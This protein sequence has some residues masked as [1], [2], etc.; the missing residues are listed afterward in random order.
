MSKFLGIELGSTRIKAVLVDGS[1]EV[2]AT[3]SYNWENKLEG[4]Y[5]TY[6]LDE[7]WV[8]LQSC[9][10]DLGAAL[11]GVTA[12]GISAMMHGYLAFDRMGQL[13]VPFRTWRN[14]SAGPAADELSAL[15][16]FHLP[17]RWSASHLYQAILNDEK[18]VKDIAYITTLAGYVHWR[19]TGEQVL[20]IGD[21][22]GMF[23]ID[24]DTLDYHAG[25]LAQFDA[26]AQFAQ[27]K[28]HCGLKTILPKIRAA[29]QEAGTLTEEGARLLDPTGVLQAGIPLCPPEGD[30]GTGMVA[31]NSVTARSGNVSAG[32]SIFAMVV[33][34]QSLSAALREIDIVAT[35]AGK[36]VAMVHCNNCTSDIDA[37]AGLFMQVFDQ[38]GVDIAKPDL[39]DALYAAA[40]EGKAD[41][42]GLLSYNFYA[43]EPMAGIETGGFLLH[44][45]PGSKF[46]PQNLMRSLVFSSVASLRIGLD[47][48]VREQVQLDRIT[49]HGGLFKSDGAQQ[50]V[51]AALGVPVAVMASAGEGGA[52]G[53]AL[54]AAYM[55]QRLAG[56]SLEDYLEQKVFAGQDALAIVPEDTD[57][58]GFACYLERYKQGLAA[59][60]AAGGIK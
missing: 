9:V 40:L 15:F 10:R 43:A 38:M 16:E 56:E 2:L 20:G 14:T 53:I 13:L 45:K 55:A 8:G 58:Q 41:C 17:Q 36:Q 50:L 26:Q 57:R 51:A 12:M 44:R 49:G 5:W 30:A 54:L 32:T 7:A 39:Y 59:A 28:P 4:G 37:W 1:H 35:P 11:Q 52:W 48:L 24:S 25:M 60:R 47:I 18:H 42:D 19:L 6:S 34:E 27:G 23:P 29:G 46:S 31:T 22:S 3:A 21:A 33:L